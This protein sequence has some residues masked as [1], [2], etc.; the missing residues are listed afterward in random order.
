MPTKLTKVQNKEK[1]APSSRSYA[2]NC[3]NKVAYWRYFV[4]AVNT[5]CIKDAKPISTAD[6]NA[7]SVTLISTSLDK[8][9]ARQSSSSTLIV[10]VVNTRGA[11]LLDNAQ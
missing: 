11:S 10:N 4:N 7:K 2:V 8:G 3:V 6:S 9:G 1:S 5:Q